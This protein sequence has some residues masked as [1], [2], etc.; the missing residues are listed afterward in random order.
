[1]ASLS[2][3]CP[4]SLE[5]PYSTNTNALSLDTPWCCWSSHFLP[6]PE[7]RPASTSF[8]SSGPATRLPL[9]SRSFT[10]S[11][12]RWYHDL[13]LAIFSESCVY[14][15]G[16]GVDINID[17][18]RGGEEW[19]CVACRRSAVLTFRELASPALRLQQHDSHVLAGVHC[20]PM[21]SNNLHQEV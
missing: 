16:R 1:M 9:T 13:S 20:C 12:F 15:N 5:A 19:D 17:S 11:N 4:A 18:H 14:S 6:S 2:L 21:P 3:T 10:I 8:C 7:L